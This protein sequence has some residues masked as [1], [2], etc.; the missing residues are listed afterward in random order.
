MEIHLVGSYTNPE[1]LAVCHLGGG[2]VLPGSVARG[3]GED[4][5]GPGKHPRKITFYLFCNLPLSVSDD[6][7]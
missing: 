3:G 1:P 6:T 7:L 5:E 4:P 2:R